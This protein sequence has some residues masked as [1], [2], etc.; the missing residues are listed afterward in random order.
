MLYTIL[1][2]QD[3]FSSTETDINAFDESLSRRSRVL[4]PG[5]SR[6][7]H[8]ARLLAAIL[9][10]NNVTV[11]SVCPA[12]TSFLDNEV[13]FFIFLSGSLLLLLSEQLGLL[14]SVSH[15]LLLFKPLSNIVSIQAQI[16]LLGE[17]K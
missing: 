4:L 2:S 16:A 10:F 11:L 6:E 1:T 7:L 13:G 8:L 14:D 17:F 15:H 12:L 3:Q 5:L 9:F